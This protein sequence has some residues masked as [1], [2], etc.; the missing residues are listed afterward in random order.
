MASGVC[1]GR[2]ASIVP[3]QEADVLQGVCGS[4]GGATE[5]ATVVRRATIS[6]SA[7]DGILP[8]GCLVPRRSRSLSPLR[9]GDGAAPV[10]DDE[11]A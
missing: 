2:V 7:L 10:V 9:L 11:R 8:S 1:A 3:N 4:L 6:P 5:L